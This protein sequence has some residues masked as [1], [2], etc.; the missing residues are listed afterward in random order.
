MEEAVTAEEEEVARIIKRRLIPHTMILVQVP[1]IKATCRA[2]TTDMVVLHHLK[3]LTIRIIPL[4][5]HILPF[6][7]SRVLIR[8]IRPMKVRSE[9]MI[10]VFVG[11]VSSLF[12]VSTQ[13]HISQGIVCFPSLPSSPP[14]PQRISYEIQLRRH[15]SSSLL[16]EGDFQSQM[17]LC[18][19][20]ICQD[21]GA[22]VESLS[23][24]CHSNPFLVACRFFCIPVPSLSLPFITNL[25]VVSSL[26]FR[27]KS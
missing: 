5:P 15:L 22:I 17:T 19:S 20:T 11:C 26:S 13:D 7:N 10:E 1:M 21:L 2:T 23:S 4:L 24:H 12:A 18:S 14:D 3:T 16:R 27:S 9:A 6:Q 8:I 25:T